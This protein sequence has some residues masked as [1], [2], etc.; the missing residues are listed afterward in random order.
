MW[1]SNTAW[2]LRTVLEFDIIIMIFNLFITLLL[3]FC[4]DWLINYLPHK[5]LPIAGPIAWYHIRVQK[6]SQI[7]YWAILHDSSSQDLE[8]RERQLRDEQKRLEDARVYGDRVPNFPPLPEFFPC[9]PCVYHNIDFDIAP[10]HQLTV[11]RVFYHWQCKC[12][13]EAHVLL[14]YTTGNS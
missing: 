9:T 14:Y 5:P 8:R 4:L 6:N 1:G 3:T 11:R 13:L 2:C 10:E 7:A 12:T